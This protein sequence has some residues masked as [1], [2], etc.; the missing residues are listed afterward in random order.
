MTETPSPGARRADPAHTSRLRQVARIVAPLL[1]VAVLGVLLVFGDSLFGD[2]DDAPPESAEQAAETT[3]VPEE[4]VDEAL[5]EVERAAGSV[6]EAWSRPETPYRAWWRRFEPLLTPGGRQAYALTDPAQ[7]PD[8]GTVEA[9][10]VV[11]HDTGVTATAWFE[12][13][14]GRFGVDLSRKGKNAQW[15][16]NRVVFPDGKSM[17]G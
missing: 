12:T 1:I 8:L 15:L 9:A 4:E 17:F 16:A 3:P 13:E 7:V 2:S 14:Q 6:L 5:V 10:D 11:I